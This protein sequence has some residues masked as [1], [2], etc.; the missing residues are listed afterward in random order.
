MRYKVNL[1]RNVKYAKFLTSEI[2]RISNV[3][4]AKIF[5]FKAE[6]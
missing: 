4:G 1:L 3:K 5:F 2:I 6:T